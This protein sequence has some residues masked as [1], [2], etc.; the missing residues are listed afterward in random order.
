MKKIPILLVLACSMSAFAQQYSTFFTNS[1]MRVD[2]YH[3]GTKGQE[4]MALDKVYS[5]GP[6]PGSKTQLLDELNLGDY[7]LRVFDCNTNALI[8]SHGFSSM[9]NEW[10]TTDEAV[11]GFLRTFQETVRFPF[12]R[13]RVTISI[14]RRDKFVATGEKLTFR[15]VFTAAIDP[16]NPTEINCEKKQGT[17]KQFDVVIN[18]PSETKVDIL[19]LGDGY[20]KQ[21]M[22][23]FRKDA[24]HFAETLLN[25]SPFKEH[26]K[27]FNVRAIEVVS[28]ESGIDKPDK[29]VWKNSALNTMYDT[30]GSARYVLIDDNKTLRDI[31]GTAPYDYITVLINDD[32]YGGGGIYN[33]YTTAF[34]KTDSPGQEW[35]MDYVYVHEF[36]HC[37]GG[38]GDEY[39][40]SQVSYTDLYPKGIEPWE[41]NITAKKS[42]AELKWRSFVDENT[43]IP[44]PWEKTEFDSLEAL[45]GKLDRLAPDYYQ[46]REPLMKLTTEILKKTKYAGRVGA[47]EGASYV[48]KGLYR[49]AA[50]CRMFTLS[51]ADFDPVCAAAIN[52]VIATH[53]K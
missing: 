23:K 46:K 27:D 29:N 36:G 44:T 15:E 9:F 17:L 25:T 42:K 5:E 10:Q 41:P 32:R 8:F 33:Q 12:P 53:V 34:T 51:L 37:F 11:N 6:W 18:G 39:Y 13:Q 1:T 31:A 16:N 14:S 21:D 7:L 24:K 4:S 45:R 38:L 52:A 20:T 43:P 2:Y 35:Q 40:T 50:D 30:F 26:K 49:P 48:T 47:F 28:E 19:I 22:D 3:T